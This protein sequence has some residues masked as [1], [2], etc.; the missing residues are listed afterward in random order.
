LYLA[1]VT[2]E[3]LPWKEF[4]KRYDRAQTIFYLDP[5][6]YEV[7]YYEHNLELEDYR[8][9]SEILGGIKS[10]FILSINDHPRMRDIFKR[11]KLKSV[12]LKYSVSQ[13]EQTKAK[14]LLITN[15]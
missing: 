7:P 4:I 9:M 12:G 13:C 5:P 8:D 11:F 15:F 1:E 6:Y 3:N 14:E 10:T 2:I